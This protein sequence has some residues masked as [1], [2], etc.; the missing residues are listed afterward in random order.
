MLHQFIVNAN[1]IDNTM[2]QQMLETLPSKALAFG[3]RV[4]FSV[5]VFFI[6]S[7]LIK[8]V[9]K[10][11]KKALKKAEAEVGVIQ[12]LDSFTKMGLYILL[13]FSIATTFGV[14]AASVVALIGSAGVAIGLALQGSLSNFAGGVLILLLK[15]FV[16]GD[17]IK[18]D[19]AGNEGTVS[20]IQLFYTKL[21]T[22]DNKVIVLPNGT[23]ANSSLTNFSTCDIRQLELK[24]GIS[25]EADIKAAKKVLEDLMLGESKR[26]TDKDM[27][28]FVDELADSCV[29][30]SGRCWVKNIDYWE[31]RRRLLEELKYALDEAGIGIP[32]PQL[33]VH[34][35]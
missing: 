7:K 3:M 12:F 20:E 26:L 30:I 2:I 28:V 18:E 22:M 6:G 32:Y 34:M 11:I 15:P 27:T 33:D 5:I 16:V 17:Y 29:V 10:I 35:K 24:V 8:L 14:D 9:R 13:V 23:L 1:L 4:V 19:S 21:K 31:V 25:Y